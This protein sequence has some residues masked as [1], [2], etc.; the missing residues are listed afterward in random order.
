M[1]TDCG[2]FD[3]LSACIFDFS[4]HVIMFSSNNS[5]S[6]TFLETFYF[7]FKDIDV[8]YLFKH[9]K[10]QDPDDP[11]QKLEKEQYQNFKRAKK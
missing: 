4:Q 11:C 5:I 1:L 7:L 6:L 8:R 2:Y 9:Q 10:G 3:L